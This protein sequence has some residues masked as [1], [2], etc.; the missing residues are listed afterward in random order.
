[1][2]WNAWVRKNSWADRF[3]SRTARVI[4]VRRW[5]DSLPTSLST[6]CVPIPTRRISG[7]TAKLSTCSLVLCSS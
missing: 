7:A 2:A 5:L 3:D 1:M 4:L 6:I